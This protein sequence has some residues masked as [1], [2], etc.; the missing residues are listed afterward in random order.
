MSGNDYSFPMP[1]DIRKVRKLHRLFKST[2]TMVQ[3]GWS[4]NAITQFYRS[5]LERQGFKEERFYTS[6]SEKHVSMIFTGLPGGRAVSIQAVDA[7][8]DENLRA[9]T[10]YIEKDN[11]SREENHQ[12]FTENIDADLSVHTDWLQRKV[13]LEEAEAHNLVSDDRLG[14]NPVTF[15]F[16]NDEWKA[17]VGRMAEGDELWEFISPEDTWRHLCGRAGIAVVRGGKVVDALITKL[18]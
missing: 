15:G 3:T 6:W 5:E 4:L 8:P 7:A 9:V 2:G 11:Y 14:K 12:D 18:N 13:T 17:L 10:L 1:G 16:Q